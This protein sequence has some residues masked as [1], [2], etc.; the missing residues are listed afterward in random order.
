[1]NTMNKQKNLAMRYYNKLAHRMIAFDA[2]VG[3]RSILNRCGFSFVELLVVMAIIG[4]LAT[5]VLPN[6]TLLRNRAKS[7]QCKS[8]LREV[9]RNIQAYNLDKGSYPATL[10]ATVSQVLKDP[11]G[12]Q[13]EYRNIRTGT[14]T[15][16]ATDPYSVSIHG[17]DDINDDF[18]LFSLGPDN[19]TTLFVIPDGT[20]SSDDIIRAVD[21][22]YVGEAKY[23]F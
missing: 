3:P 7:A 10:D 2:P 20:F 4:I 15:P 13:Y 1:M 19:D 18:D 6:Y 8:D 21:G 17:V 14:G 12:H 22:G 9:E 11:W 23:Y 16:K 5:M